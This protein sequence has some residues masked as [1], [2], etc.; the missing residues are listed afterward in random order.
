MIEQK[1]KLRLD[2]L[3]VGSFVI[4]NHLS[5]NDE[6]IKGGVTGTNIFHTGVICMTQDAWANSDFIG[7]CDESVMVSLCD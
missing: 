7:Y 3:E 6:T 1:K 2:E 5:D 4:N